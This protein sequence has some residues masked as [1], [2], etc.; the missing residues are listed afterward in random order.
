MLQVAHTA[1]PPDNRPSITQGAFVLADS[2]GS[3]F[4]ST[5]NDQFNVRAQGGVRFVTS[6]AGLTV[7]G[8]PLLASGGGSG[9]TIQYNTNGR[10]NL[11]PAYPYLC[12]CQH[13]GRHHCR[14]RRHQL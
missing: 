11:V 5:A 9:I 12:R 10:P 13:H 3:S 6:G 4:A 2:Q 7:D 1:L 8:F 14:R